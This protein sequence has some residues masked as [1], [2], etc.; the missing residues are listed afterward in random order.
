MSKPTPKVTFEHLID[1]VRQAEDALE[2]HERATGAATRQLAQAW[3]AGWTPLRIVSAGLVAGFLVGRAEPMSKVSGP[4]LLQMINTVSGLFASIKVAGAARDAEAAA[5][6]ATEATEAAQGTAPG[7][8]V[9]TPPPPGPAPG[10]TERVRA[11]RPHTGEWNDEPRP[12][13]AATEVSER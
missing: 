1:K 9:G 2:H 3:R 12:A 8:A 13:E 4:R 6:E 10:P 11:S 7:P 5:D